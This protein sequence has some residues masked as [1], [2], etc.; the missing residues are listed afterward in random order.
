MQRMEGQT[1]RHAYILV[2][3]IPPKKYVYSSS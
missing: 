2:R 1:E 3:C